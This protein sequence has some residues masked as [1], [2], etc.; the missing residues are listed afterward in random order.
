MRWPYFLCIPLLHIS[1]FVA[2]GITLTTL[3]LW[4][5][6]S[7]RTTFE[8]PSKPAFVAVYAADPSNVLI[9]ALETTFMIHP[10]L[11]STIFGKTDLMQNI[12]PLRFVLM[13]AS[14]SVSVVV[15]KDLKTVMPAALMRTSTLSNFF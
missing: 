10:D 8:R 14:N 7:S 5:R 4:W 2:P 11:R 6:I 12:G 15:R 9:A 1:V 13:M 3:I